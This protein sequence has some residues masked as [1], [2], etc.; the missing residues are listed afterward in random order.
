MTTLLFLCPSYISSL[1]S[2]SCVFLLQAM[3]FLR[4][5]TFFVIDF[6][7]F[8]PNH[9]YAMR[10]NQLMKHLKLNYMSHISEKCYDNRGAKVA[11]EKEI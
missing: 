9:S 10:I 11:F 5:L 2:I 1:D 6:D 8:F 3:T 4:S 7:R